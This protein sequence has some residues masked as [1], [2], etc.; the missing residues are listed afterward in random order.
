DTVERFT[1]TTGSTGKPKLNPVTS[2][3]LKEYRNAWDIWGLKILLDHPRIVGGKILQMVGT[4]NMGRTEGG[5]PISMIS[6]LATRYQHPLVRPFYSIPYEISDIRDPVARYYATLRL[7]VAD[8]VTLVVAMN[9][10]TLLRLIEL[11]DQ[12][13]QDLVRD[14]YD[15][16]LSPQFDI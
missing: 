15:G 16:T 14:I 10:G 9:P 4:W 11:G 2:T 13:R 1:I 8:D 7:G 3:W 12:R 5:L 6:T